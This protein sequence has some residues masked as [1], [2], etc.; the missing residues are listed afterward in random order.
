LRAR[1]VRIPLDDLLRIWLIYQIEEVVPY[2]LLVDLD[3]WAEAAA[4]V[5]S[6][7]SHGKTQVDRELE[8]Q[9]TG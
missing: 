5:D 3:G 6:W 7:G 9:S 2:E 4:I 1:L 8:V